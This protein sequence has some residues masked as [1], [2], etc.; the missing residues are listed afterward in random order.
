MLREGMPASE[1][2]VIGTAFQSDVMRI[3]EGNTV[4]NGG[5]RCEF[6]QVYSSLH[7]ITTTSHYQFTRL[8]ILEIECIITK[9]N[10]S[11][12][13]QIYKSIP[14][15]SIH[16][17]ILHENSHKTQVCQRGVISNWSNLFIISIHHIPL[18]NSNEA[19]A[20]L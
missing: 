4:S 20:K 8:I 15:Q 12:F 19:Y 16:S 2:R 6:R 14:F 11:Q 1:K 17:Q 7:F 9:P 10:G 18:F 5:E 3:A 13:G